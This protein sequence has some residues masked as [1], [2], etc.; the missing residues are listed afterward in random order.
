VG[1]LPAIGQLELLKRA[2]GKRVTRAPEVAEASGARPFVIA[3]LVV[4][5]FGLVVGRFDEQVESPRTPVAAVPTIAEDLPRS[6]ALVQRAASVDAKSAEQWDSDF[7]AWVERKYQYLLADVGPLR[8]KLMPLLLGRENDPDLARIEDEIRALLPAA[9]YATF[10]LLRES[11]EEQH[12]LLEFAGGVSNVTPLTAQ[13]QR[14]V[15]EIK[16]RHKQAYDAAVRQSGLQRIALSTAERAYAHGAVASAL[17]AYRTDYLQEVRQLL[18]D[19]QYVLLSNYESTEF[20]R[21]L[22]RLQRAIN[23]K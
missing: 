9:H 20:D 5:A 11:D 8:A 21:E 10:Q 15:L 2:T 22:Q 18:D 23:A 1:E 14:A 4:A 19:E 16:L 17:R 3:A 12:H 13:Q 6:P 7:V